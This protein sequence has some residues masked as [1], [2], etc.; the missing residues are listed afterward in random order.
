MKQ[1]RHWLG[2]L[3][4]DRVR[5]VTTEEI[6]ADQKSVLKATLQFLGLCP[7]KFGNLGKDNV[8]PF[9]VRGAMRINEKSFDKLKEFFEPYNRHLYALIGRDL[10]WESAKFDK[11][12]K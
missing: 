5:V 7:Y 2:V 9:D 1:V 8:T 10:G 4:H 3:G 11:Y 12:R 6:V